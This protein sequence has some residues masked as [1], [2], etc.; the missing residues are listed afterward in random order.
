M[1]VTRTN[2]TGHPLRMKLP[3]VQRFRLEREAGGGVVQPTPP[4]SSVPAPLSA[5]PPSRRSPTS[6]AGRNVAVS[7]RTKARRRRRARAAPGP[8]R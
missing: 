7:E 2:E 1:A 8:H 5:S 3:V 6:K 4:P